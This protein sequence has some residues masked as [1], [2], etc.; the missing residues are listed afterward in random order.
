MNIAQMRTFVTVIDHG[1]FSDAAKSL[2]ISQPAVTMQLQALESEL[3]AKLLDRRYRRIDLTESGRALE[4]HA[5]RVL[6]EVQTARKE[7]QSLSGEV[8]GALEI[9]AST[10]PGVY[11]IPLVLGAFISRYPGVSVRVTSED[12]AGVIEAVESGRAQVGV[13]GAIVKGARVT[14]QPLLSD[15]LIAICPPGCD[16]SARKGVNLADL[17]D[18]EW[19]VREPGSGTR[20]VAERALSDAG[21]EPSTLR[22]V[23][24]LGTGEAIVAAVEGGLGVAM[25]SRHVAEKSLELGRVARIDIAGPPVLRPFFTVLAKGTPTRAALAFVNH[26]QG[27]TPPDAGADAS[28]SFS[29]SQS[30][31]PRTR[32]AV[33]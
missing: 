20:Q 29:S 14:F 30:P 15:E 27:R 4:P 3:G 33:V 2:G 21:V 11:V 13:S 28:P 9:A 6:S 17:A 19:V 25:L 26:L 31:Q 7:L 18:A 10:T 8:S 24:Q 5:R 16:L 1:S 23:A 22:V 32:S 12:T